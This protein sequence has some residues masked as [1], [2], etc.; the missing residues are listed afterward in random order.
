[1]AG[2]ADI[3]YL[4]ARKSGSSR[5]GMILT[6]SKVIFEQ[7][8][9]LVPLFEGF[10]T[11]GGMSTKEIEAIAVGL[12]E[13][14]NED[15]AGSSPSMVQFLVSMLEKEGVPVI[16][17]AGALGCHVDAMKFIPHV[18]QNQYPAG[19]LAAA[20]FIISGTR[21]MERGTISTDRAQSGEE[22][23]ADVELLRLAIPRRAYTASQMMFVADRLKWLLEHKDLVGGLRF[24]EE[25]PVLRFFLG[26]LEAVSDWP[27]R[28]VEAFRKD[29]GEI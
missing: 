17:P 20:Y 21:G 25:P 27:Q 28:L 7:M 3:T 23:M 6:N 14:L 8:R 2:L 26:R 16:T 10:L 15:V 9:D 4:S 29:F 5:G 22:I 19:A 13:M 24:V 1:M 12:M 18:P 11:Y